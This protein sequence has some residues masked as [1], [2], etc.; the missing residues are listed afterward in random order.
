[1]KLKFLYISLLALVLA[2]CNKNT[3]EPSQT[4]GP[5]LFLK[6]ELNGEQWD[7]EAGIDGVYL[8][9]DHSRNKYGVYEFTGSFNHVGNDQESI[10]IFIQDE[11][12]RM[13]NDNTLN[14]NQSLTERDYPLLRDDI[15]FDQNTIQFY[16]YNDDSYLHTWKINDYEVVEQYP[17]IEFSLEDSL[18]VTHYID[19]PESF[20]SDSI[21]QVI[22]G[23]GDSQNIDYL[24]LP[25]R[26][27]WLE[28]HSMRLEYLGDEWEE[29]ITSVNWHFSENGTNYY[30]EGRSF[31]H[32]FE[33]AGPHQV[34]MLVTKEL[35]DGNS[36]SFSYIQKVYADEFEGDCVSSA[37]FELVPQ[38]EPPGSQVVIE[39]RDSNGDIWSSFSSE[40]EEED[41][42][43]SVSQVDS[44]IDNF[45]GLA[46]KKL[47]VAFSCV[48]YKMTDPNQTMELNN[49]SGTI[50]V[51]YPQ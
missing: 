29:E 15:A 10:R 41:G 45:D 32:S 22:Y 6:G 37:L 49:F 28:G 30:Y 14:I 25:F 44:Y 24:M 50:A 42:F 46:T 4:T 2:S 8:D 27:V 48:L 33:T 34:V 47:N 43:F 20:C 5:E 26:S 18:V 31:T 17:T 1:M 3:L 39:Y 21:T 11:E 9:A 19:S 38:E 16:S 7:I 35:E 51:S 13:P 12:R 40:I 36:E 23:F